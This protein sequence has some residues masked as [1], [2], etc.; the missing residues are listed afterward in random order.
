M[1]CCDDFAVILTSLSAFND[2][3]PRPLIINSLV[4]QID[5]H[6]RCPTVIIMKNIFLNKGI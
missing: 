3:K 2:S 5:K 6:L 1:N 4:R